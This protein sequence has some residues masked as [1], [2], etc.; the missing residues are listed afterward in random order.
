MTIFSRQRGF[1]GLVRKAGIGFL[2]LAAIIGGFAAIVAISGLIRSNAETIDN[3][4]RVS[5]D[6]DLTYYLK[7]KYDGVDR[8]GIESNDSTTSEVRSDVIS[9]SDRIPNGLTFV[10]F[11]ESES[12]SF[13]AVERRD[14]TTPCAGKVVDDTGDTTGWNATNTEYVYHGLHFDKASNTVNFQVKNLKGGCELSVG[15]VTHTP[16][17][18]EG[19]RRMDFYNMA[20]ISE[21]PLSASSNTVHTWIGRDI[22]VYEVKYSYT[23]DIPANAPALPDNMAFPENMEVYV[24]TDARL[25]GYTFSGWTSTD[26]AITNGQFTMPTNE[27]HIVG[28]FTAKPKYQVSYVIDGD[29]VPASYH[30]PNPKEYGENDMVEVDSLAA[31][32]VIDGYKFSGWSTSDATISAEG[33]FS[34]PTNAV[35]LHGS[36]EQVKHTVTYAFEGEVLPPSAPSL[37]PAAE[38]YAVGATVT[39]AANPTAEGYKFSGWYKSASFVMPDE[40]VKI[41][42]EWS[43]D[44]GSFK[45]ILTYEIDD[46]KDP[47]YNTETVK[48]TVKVKN[49]ADYPISMVNVQLKD[50]DGAHFVATRS[51]VIRNDHLAQINE[52]GAGETA[53]LWA[54]FTIPSNEDVDYQSTAELISAVAENNH[55]L[56]MEDTSTYSDT[57]NFRSTRFEQDPPLAGINQGYLIPFVVLIA[58]GAVGGM[59]VVLRKKAKK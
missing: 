5:E 9:V 14:G 49:T 25:D 11:V 51:F 44:A 12:G 19:V 13:G 28:S 43:V 21:G 54:E 57:V 59:V 45:P 18:P 33:N 15:I 7:V 56:D 50:L 39:T 42:G 22:P 24:A 4:V 36:F 35:V 30:A 41:Y 1:S 37:L 26:V 16:T 17:L 23:G 31:N 10:S 8:Q 55:R 52:I 29:E 47:Y 58:V 38:D 20:G 46:Y 32:A 48:L 6:S 40:D 27:V 53:T 34:M 2:S 3:G